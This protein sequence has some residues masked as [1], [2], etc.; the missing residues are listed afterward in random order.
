MTPDRRTAALAAGITAFVAALAVSAGALTLSL[1]DATVVLLAFLVSIVGVRTLSRRRGVRSQFD[2]PETERTIEVP[3]P[4]ESLSE[5]VSSFRRVDSGYRTRGRRLGDGL[6]DAVVAVLTRFEGDDPET[7]TKRLEDGDWTDDPVAAAFLSEQ[8][9]PPERSL[10]SRVGRVFDR[11]YETEFQRGVRHVVA[12]IA[13]IG[14]ERGP[15]A[16]SDDSDETERVLPAYDYDRTPQREID[17]RRTTTESVDGIETVRSAATEYWS[18]IGVVALFAVGIGAAVESPAVL[19]AG[20]VGIGYAGFAR[21]FEP[22]VLELSIDRTVSDET[23]EPG[24]EIDVTVAITNESG[25]FVPDLRFVDGV[26][27]G[28]VVTEGSSRLGTALRPGESVSLEYT[29]AVKRGSHEFDPALA[30]TRDLSRSTEREFRIESETA[31]V[32]EP[33]MRPVA[34]PVPLRTTATSFAGRLT[35]TE[36]GAGTTFHSVREYRPNDP[37]SRIDWNRRAKTGELATLEFHAERSARAVVLVDARKGAYLAPAPD[38]T[39][40]VDR[41]IAAA[42]RIGA[43]LLEAGHSVGLAGIGPVGRDGDPQRGTDPCWLA[44]ASGRHHELEFREL[45]ATHPQFDAV[46]PEQETPWLTQLRTLRRRLSAE[47]QI[48]LLTPLCDAGSADIARRLEARGH[49]VTVVSPDPTVDATAGGRLAQVARRVRRFDLERAGIRVIDWPDGT[50]IDEV[51]ARQ[52]GAG[53]GTAVDASGG[54]SR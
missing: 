53:T 29:A 27:P 44:P 2:T 45:L 42:G 9:E 49:P 7:A 39:H 26:P 5:T 17:G 51:F 23:P 32:C 16:D 11:G 24:D 8:L 19:L 1:T 13:S 28:L 20:V 14:Y 38:A 30:I 25:G 12:A 31:V 15:E 18:G 37:L 50:S 35:T 54:G 33:E 10:R 47:T 52:A 41:S 21:A 48:V 36:G 40:A 46:A 34:A 3:V 6:Q 22:P 4:G 43:S